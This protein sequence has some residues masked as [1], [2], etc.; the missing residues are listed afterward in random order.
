[1]LGAV[2]EIVGQIGIHLDQEQSMLMADIH[3]HKLRLTEIIGH[4]DEVRGFDQSIVDESIDHL[5][6]YAEFLGA[7][8]YERAKENYLKTL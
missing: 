7:D 6:I 4:N 2:R 5:D 8:E 3:Q 1:M